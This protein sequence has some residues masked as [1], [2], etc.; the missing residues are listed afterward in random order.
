MYVFKENI[1][2][3]LTTTVTTLATASSIESSGWDLS[4]F[5]SNATSQ[6]TSWGQ[7]LVILVG[8][9]MLLVGIIKLAGAFISHGKGQPPNWVI[10]VALILVG[11]AF[12]T[13]G[14]W[15]MITAIAGG[16]KTTIESLGE[17]GAAR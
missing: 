8:L 10:I 1:M 17:P 15:E 16:G 13:A 4:N 14:S 7:L 11:G 3:T 5:L 12:M 9:I 2:F 6:I